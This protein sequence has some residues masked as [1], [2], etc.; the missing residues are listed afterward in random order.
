MTAVVARV[1]EL[2]V[3]DPHDT[4]QL[5]WEEMKRIFYAM[6]EIEL[7]DFKG[8]TMN[9][10]MAAVNHVSNCSSSH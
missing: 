6:R 2:L 9:E 4:H 1:D 7:D 5:F 8:A 3:I 10:F